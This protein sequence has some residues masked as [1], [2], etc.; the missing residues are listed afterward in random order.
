MKRL[1]LSLLLAAGCAEA[2][3]LT[4]GDDP[5]PPFVIGAMD[6]KAREG[7]AVRL[8][9]L[10]LA[11]ADPSMALEVPVMP[12]A[13]VLL[14]AREGRT[15]GVLFL[16]KT[17]EREEFFAFS[18]PLLKVPLVV[19]YDRRRF[20]K[21]LAWNSIGDLAPHE[22]V[23]TRGASYGP[24][25][26]AVAR[27]RL[28]LA[29]TSSPSGCIK[30]LLAGR[31]AYTPMN[32]LTGLYLLQQEGAVAQQAIGVEERP[33]NYSSY[34]LALSKKS[35]HLGLLPALDRAVDQLRGDGTIDRLLADYAEQLR[36]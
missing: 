26:D 22:G 21:G 36:R 25:W 23:V 11:R 14:S 35:P 17:A 24:E 4:L 32:L 3:T 13:R 12:W 9:E 27:G 19:F 18:K 2:A 30:M 7:L 28:R 29:E 34:H 10:V 20:P 31:V 5:F 16:F 6:A 8:V 1:L 33:I 15:D